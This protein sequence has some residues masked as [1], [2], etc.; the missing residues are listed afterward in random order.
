MRRVCTSICIVWILSA[1]ISIPPLIGWNDWPEEFNEE[2]PCKL[3]EEKSYV[4]YSSMGSFYIP[5]FIM[6]VVY[7][8]IFQAT[9]RRLKDRAKASAIANLGNSSSQ[10]LAPATKSNNTNNNT[11]KIVSS[12]EDSS[13]STSPKSSYMKTRRYLR[14]CFEHH[15]NDHH[16]SNNDKSMNE[17]NNNNNNSNNGKNKK[18]RFSRKILKE[19][20]IEI[21]SASDDHSRVSSS[22][23]YG[24]TSNVPA[25]Y[26]H[27]SFSN[28]DDFD[29]GND[30]DEDDDDNKSIDADI[31][32]GEFEIN[33]RVS[34]NNGDDDDDEQEQNSENSE[35]KKSTTTSITNQHQHQQQQN[36]SPNKVFQ[37]EST[38][39]NNSTIIIQSDKNLVST[40]SFQTIIRKRERE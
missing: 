16:R 27:D 38:S 28:E 33:N 25:T 37:M 31:P 18:L 22:D 20:R 15:R 6:T 17:N 19:T 14:C 1:I 29:D 21:E 3:S 11:T 40:N 4:I 8:K 39:I 7:F 13:S 34:N 5:L 30:F 9:R 26:H 10:P 32:I 36:S 24:I 12:Y 35:M 2:T 23:A